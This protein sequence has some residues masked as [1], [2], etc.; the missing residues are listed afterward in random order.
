ML[1]SGGLRA[2]KSN[3]LFA[4][5]NESKIDRAERK[6]FVRAESMNH[7]ADERFAHARLADDQ[8]MGIA[9][10]Q[11][12]KCVTDAADVRVGADELG[13]HGRGMVGGG[14]TCG[15]ISFSQCGDELEENELKVSYAW[16]FV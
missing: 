2:E 4:F 7:S 10:C 1:D 5:G 3:A 6:V 12:Q 14:I 11:C 15:M 9:I 8:N 16:G 13:C